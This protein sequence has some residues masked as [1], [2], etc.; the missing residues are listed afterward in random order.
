MIS[1]LSN[2]LQVITKMRDLILFLTIF[3]TIILRLQ[4]GVAC[5]SWVNLDLFYYPKR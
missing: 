1:I 4:D 5:S 3:Y 2:I